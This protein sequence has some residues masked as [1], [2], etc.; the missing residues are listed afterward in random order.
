M[1]WAGVC[2]TGRTPLVFVERGAKINTDVYLNDILKKEM[3]PWAQEHFGS[4]TWTF[5]QDGAPAHNSKK[6][7]EWCARNLPDF[8]PASEW[9][10][11]SPDLNL[12]D[13]C[14]W[15]IL[16][17][18]ACTERHTTI[19]GLK[20]SLEKAWEEIPQA[21]LRAAIESYPKRLQAV[22]RAKGGHIE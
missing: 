5:Q 14:V 13:Y 3:L 2:A 1:V 7:Q 4:T 6:T 21:T 8:I 22:I 12:M 19:Q 20:S 11:N 16:K 17:E 10:A 18:K 9:P 15:S